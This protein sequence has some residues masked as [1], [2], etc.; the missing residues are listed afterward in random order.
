M[1]PRR[2][3]APVW[4][5]AGLPGRVPGM[6]LSAG[7]SSSRPLAFRAIVSSVRCRCGCFDQTCTHA[8]RLFFARTHSV[9]LFARAPSRYDCGTVRPRATERHGRIEERLDSLPEAPLVA[10]RGSSVFCARCAAPLRSVTDPR[11]HAPAQRNEVLATNNPVRRRRSPA[12]TQRRPQR[13]P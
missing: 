10:E 4:S 13:Q 11:R 9:T 1:P 2:E 6:R 8:S 3:L 12:S 7:G 5:W